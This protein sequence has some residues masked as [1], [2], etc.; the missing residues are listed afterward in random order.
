MNRLTI[1]VATMALGFSALFGGDARSPESLGARWARLSDEAQIQLLV[2]ELIA[3]RAQ[4]RIALR[5]VGGSG[6]DHTVG[7]SLIMLRKDDRTVTVSGTTAFVDFADGRLELVKQ[8][9]QWRATGG[10]VP[11]RETNDPPQT[12]SES[13]GSSVGRTFVEVPVSRDH[14]IDRLTRNITRS[15]INRDLFSVP[16]KSASF[17]R[18]RYLRQAPYVE[19]T[20]IQFVTD[21]EWSRVVYG[22]MNRWIKAYEDVKGPSAIAVDADGRVF[23]GEAGRSRV[24][25]LRVV[26]TGADARLEHAFTL[27]D[28]ESPTDIALDDNGTPLQTTDD[29]LFV[30]DAASNEI[31]CFDLAASG[32]TLRARF[33]GFDSPTGIVVGKTN[34]ASNGIIYVID[35][36]ARRVRAFEHSSG[37]LT[38]LKEH[39]GDYQ[40]YFKTIKTDHFGNI[41]LVDAV[42]SELTK[43]T[44]G[45]EVLDSKGGDNTYVA[46]S[47]LDIPFGRIEVEGEGTYWAGFDQ[48]FAIEHW[49]EA[50]GVQ[51]N[52]LGLSMRN[53]AFSTDA[54]ISAITTRFTLTDHANVSI[55]IVNDAQRLVRTLSGSWMVSGRK[56]IVWDRRNDAGVQVP[57]GNYRYEIV[58]VPAYREEPIS[59]RTRFFLPLYY[60]ENCGSQLDDAHLVQGSARV[61]GTE[62]SRT[63]NEHMSS[64]QYRFTGLRPEAD[65][66]LALE[67]ASNDNVQRMQ[68]VSAGGHVIHAPV[69]VSSVPIRLDYVKLPKESYA[70]GDVTISV[71]RRGQ[72]SAIVTQLWFK[73]VGTFEPQTL[74]DVVPTTYVLEQNY[75]NPFNPSTVIR[76]AVPR[77][78]HVLLTVYD[79]TGRQVAALV[80][81]HRTAGVYEVR[82]DAA[83]GSK[84]LSSGVYF[85]R[86]RAGDFTETRKMVL[87]R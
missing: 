69:S 87:L 49:G 41:Y 30:A 24:A 73:E 60:W 33:G 48:L 83:A 63:A 16:A 2:D 70:A 45:L 76:Y 39:T 68:D 36:L 27:T 52:T 35:K 54:D 15:R 34:G 75:P 5:R 67:F 50:N 29:C 74:N 14:D 47:N 43:L 58:G 64:V 61:W 55:R 6:A 25:V 3:S 42:N 81:E 66:E 77:D 20:Y 21:P 80:D 26:G 53:I 4:D 28:I 46:L 11:L 18:A 79:I 38:L 1:A 31:L 23:I 84:A 32:G 8:D 62:P 65:Y 17:Y 71:N 82:F 37:R 72:G 44:P 86:V 85:Y 51:R 7:T 57:P 13:E 59:S 19:A 12:G 40:Q 9:G 10:L 22:N 78:G 56:T